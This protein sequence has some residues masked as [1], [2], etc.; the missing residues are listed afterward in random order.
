MFISIFAYIYVTINQEKEAVALRVGCHRSSLRTGNW[1][2][3][4]G[5]KGVGESSVILLQLKTF[6]KKKLLL[7]QDLSELSCF[8]LLVL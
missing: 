4:E 6:K 1:A 7:C 3:L 2:E 5:S 8:L